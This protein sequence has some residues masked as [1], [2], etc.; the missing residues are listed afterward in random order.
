MEIM[1]TLG[2]GILKF[3]FKSPASFYFKTTKLTCTKVEST[4][5]TQIF[6]SLE[7]QQQSPC[8]S[9]HSIMTQYH[10]VTDILD[11]LAEVNKV[12]N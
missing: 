11:R 10:N 5:V 8:V 2:G 3:F 12:Y 1:K 9:N 6:K 4:T 7:C